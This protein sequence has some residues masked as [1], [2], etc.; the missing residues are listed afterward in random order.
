MIFARDTYSAMI[1]H[2]QRKLKGEFHP[3]ET[4]EHKAF[5][6]LGGVVDSDRA[7]IFDLVELGRNRRADEG[8]SAEIDSMMDRFAVP[9]KTPA[10]RR[11]W[12]ADPEE[13]L[14]AQQR[15]ERAGYEMI[16]TYHTHRVSWPH[17]LLRDTCTNLDRAL[18]EK[19]GLW[20]AII[21]MVDPDQPRVRVF[22]EGD[23]DRE[24]AITF[25]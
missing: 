4:P 13:L 5:G 17:D 16:G 1:G 8:F 18:A 22:F 24:A 25:A 23:N 21:S 6:L 10:A 7:R 19:S 2:A 14:I 20:M 12:V 15:W 11:G 3:H 9:S